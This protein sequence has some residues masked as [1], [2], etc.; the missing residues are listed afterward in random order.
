[1][2]VNKQMKIWFI[3]AGDVHGPELM[4]GPGSCL[5]LVSHGILSED[6]PLKID[7]GAERNCINLQIESY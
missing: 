4:E 5:F 2:N 3:G 1:M 7:V 6:A